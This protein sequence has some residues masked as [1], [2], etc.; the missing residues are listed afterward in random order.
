L[1][2]TGKDGKSWA[3]VFDGAFFDRRSMRRTTLILVVLGLGLVLGGGHLFFGFFQDIS[4]PQPAAP[5]P[6]VARQPAAKLVVYVGVI[7]RYAPTTIYQGYQPIMDYLTEVT[8]YRFE[9][10]L[11]RTYW[12]TVEHLA[13]GK[14][15]VAF[16]GRKVYLQAR[17]RYGL[18]A[19]LKP[20]NDDYQPEFQDAV[21]TRSESAINS[22]E[23]LVGRTL[24]LPS[25]DSY[26]G[27]W[28]RAA[29]FASPGGGKWPLK[30]VRHFEHH[31]TVVY[32]VLRG[33]FDAG[34]V[35][36]SVAEEYLSK[37]VKII[38]RSE[39]VPGSPIVVG[40]QQDRVVVEAFKRALLAVD[41]R[42]PALADRLAGWD[43]EF[44][45]GFAP[46]R[47]SDYDR[48]QKILAPRGTG[49]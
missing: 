31:H 47:D 24:A 7:S 14:V 17:E 36:E 20:L 22:L 18:T 37:G 27:N 2:G 33:N 9:L 10:K 3:K 23:D 34:V 1:L 21:I 16:L 11:G 12:E 19:I 45:Y 43:K 40:K 8:P 25:Q 39:P 26:S 44:R 5:V 28:L 13:S 29:G 48:V 30:A 41:P 4:T 38:A 6:E 15:A 42:Q 46:A 49:P 35:R 32:Q